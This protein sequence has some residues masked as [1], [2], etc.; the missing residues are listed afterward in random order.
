MKQQ[1]TTRME[2]AVLD[3]I[4]IIADRERRSVNNTVEY[5]LVKAIEA[6]K[7]EN[8]LIQVEQSQN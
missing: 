8:N 6:Y 3:D 5:L 4:K 2:K 1:Y 7:K